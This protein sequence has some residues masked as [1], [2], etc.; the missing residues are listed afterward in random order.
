MLR[1]PPSVGHE[2]E[3]FIGAN[4]CFIAEGLIA[5]AKP[6]AFLHADRDDRGTTR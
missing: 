1:Y 6:G 5:P 3:R 2:D 4:G